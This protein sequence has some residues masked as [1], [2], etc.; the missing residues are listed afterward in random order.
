MLVT[1]RADREMKIEGL[2]LGADDYV[3]KPF[4]PRELK[5]RVGGLLTAR[6]LQKE[7]SIRN[8]RLEATLVELRAAE[9]QLVQAERLAAVGE[10]AAG[11][12]HEV[13]N[14]VNFAL[15][16]ARTL[17]KTA[18]EMRQ[19]VEPLAELDA[20]DREALARQAEKLGQRL[21]NLDFEEVVQ[22]LAE[23]AGIVTNGLER[24]QRLVGDL[25]DFTRSERAGTAPVD[26]RKG[27]RSTLRLIESTFHD[28]NV[29]VTTRFD[30]PLPPVLADS[31]ALN[32]V[33]LN[34]IKNAADAFEGNGGEIEVDARKQGASVVIEVRDDGPGIPASVRDRL[35]EPFVT[36]KEAG[37]GTGLGLSISRR[38]I[39]A[40]GGS[41]ELLPREERGT[42]ARV[43]L[44]SAS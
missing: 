37:H 27:L 5:A 7:L 44:P 22:D 19:V 6:S 10:L 3:T 18:D 40:H 30:D 26:V 33:F 21:D 9:V 16:A 1:S 24:T 42:V 28:Q 17:R 29:R 13:N 41:I 23:L 12:A 11:V 8:A 43:S 34:L 15:N 2:E 38:I 32:Q 20:R 35:F 25:R 14:P 39:D 4:H 36:T 31:G